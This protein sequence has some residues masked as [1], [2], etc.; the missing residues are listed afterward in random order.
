[1]AKGYYMAKYWIVVASRDHVQ[2]GILEG[3]IQACHGK[4]APLKRIKKDDYVIYYSPK[5]E[6]G[7]T[8]KCQLLT[9]LGKVT[10]D[11]VYQFQMTPGFSP[12]RRKVSFLNAKEISIIPL[13]SQ[14][15]VIK[16]KKNWGGA[17]RYGILQIPPQD[18]AL[19]VEHMIGYIPN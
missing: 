5:Y 12:F 13:I 19:I 2:K 17:F 10:D 9:A 11:I 3:I 16:N 15:T 6:F 18:F 7:G 8:Q 14:L 4:A 1:M